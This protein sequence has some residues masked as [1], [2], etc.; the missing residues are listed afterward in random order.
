VILR[1][2]NVYG[3]HQALGNPYTGI[4]PIFWSHRRAGRPIPIYE[5]GRPGRDFIHVR[6]VVRANLLALACDAG[7]N[8]I[9]VG[10]GVS[11]TITEIATAVCNALGMEPRLEFTGQFRV[12]DIRSCYADCVEARRRLGFEAMTGLSQGLADLID[13][14]SGASAEAGAY[15]E[16]VRELQ[17]KGVMRAAAGGRG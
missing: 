10:S 9:N 1:Y 8:S 5:D 16:S 3:R 12:G 11:T 2:F 6:D 4:A 17:R 7:A 15:D 13:W 14:L